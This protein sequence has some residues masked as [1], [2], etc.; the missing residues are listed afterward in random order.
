MTTEK[1]T[2]YAGP[3][4]GQEVLLPIEQRELTH[5]CA[6]RGTSKQTVTYARCPVLSLQFDKPIFRFVPDSTII[7]T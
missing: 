4:D 3:A 1:A 5:R 7:H 2:L 6:G